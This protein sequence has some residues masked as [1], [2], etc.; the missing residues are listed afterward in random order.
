[1]KYG[2]AAMDDFA[3]AI[4]LSPCSA[5]VYFNRANLFLSLEM[6]AE[7]EQDYTTGLCL[8]DPLMHDPV[9]L[10]RFS[11]RWLDGSFTGFQLVNGLTTDWHWQS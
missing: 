5:H 8:L 6:L 4:K 11:L 2:L 3:M 10:S 1:M 9:Q 7:A